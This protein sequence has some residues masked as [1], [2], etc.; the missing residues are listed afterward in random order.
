MTI[1]R[2]GTN[3]KFADGWSAVFG[4]GG[5]TAGAKAAASKPAAAPKKK[6]AAPKKKAAKKAKK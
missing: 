1:V 6:A 4:K 2:V 5:K 3:K